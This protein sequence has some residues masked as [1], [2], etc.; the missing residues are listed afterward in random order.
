M[1]AIGLIA[2]CNDRCSSQELTFM[3]GLMMI[4]AAMSIG[5]RYELCDI[6]PDVGRSA[7]LLC[8]YC[9]VW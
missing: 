8:G 6:D 2:Y 7:C 1:V 9:N 3:N 4:G 5:G